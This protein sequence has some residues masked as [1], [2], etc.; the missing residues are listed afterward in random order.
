MKC[1]WCPGEVEIREVEVLV[2]PP[3]GNPVML[4]IDALPHPDG[5]VLERDDHQFR[6]ML[7][8]QLRGTVKALYRIH[9]RKTCGPDARGAAVA[10]DARA[11]RR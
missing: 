7:P 5:Q 10:R 1:R 8:D 11:G 6:R 4:K 9:G 3:P 2:G